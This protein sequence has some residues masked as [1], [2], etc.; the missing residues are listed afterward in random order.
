MKRKM[1]T[2][3]IKEGTTM[4]DH[5]DEFNKMILDLKNVNIVLENED[6]IL[7]LAHF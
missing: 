6:K 3:S 4:K 5:L 1:Y 7:I 2:F